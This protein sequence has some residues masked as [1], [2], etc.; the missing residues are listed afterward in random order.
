MY[1]RA[2][3]DIDGQ[4]IPTLKWVRP[5]VLVA[6]VPA[7]PNPRTKVTLRV[8]RT[9]LPGDISP[10][11]TDPRHL[12]LQLSTLEA[13]TYIGKESLKKSRLGQAFVMMQER[14]PEDLV[15]AGYRDLLRR[16]PDAQGSTRYVDQIKSGE[17]TPQ[18][19]FMDLI[20][21]QEFV[22]KYQIHSISD[23][24]YKYVV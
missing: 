21:S 18:A 14:A 12:G 3:V 4:P 17:I 19:F 23:S 1:E 16:D 20:Y 8:P 22:K 15:F 6:L 9:I 10:G 11:N 2:E 24:L 13:Y 7:A 5:R